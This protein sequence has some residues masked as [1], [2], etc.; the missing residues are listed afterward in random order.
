M[1][2]LEDIRNQPRHIREIM[3]G[4]CV[5]I[6]V[7]LVGLIWFRSFEEDLF[8]LLNTDPKKQEQFFAE[9]SKNTPTLVASMRTSYDGLRAAISTLLLFEGGEEIENKKSGSTDK[10][11]LLPLPGKK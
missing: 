3:F 10:P 8:V 6:T 7:S 2:L 4:F 11:Y 1:P 9:R 5:V